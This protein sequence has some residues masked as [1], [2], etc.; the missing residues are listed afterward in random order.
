VLAD[1]KAAYLYIF[2]HHYYRIDS[3]YPTHITEKYVRSFFGEMKKFEGYNGFRTQQ[4]TGY[5]SI[6]SNKKNI[7]G[8]RLGFYTDSGT[9]VINLTRI[10]FADEKYMGNY[11]YKQDYP[12]S[13]LKE[14]TEEFEAEILPKILECIKI[15]KKK[16]E[17]NGESAN[18]ERDN[19]Y[20]KTYKYSKELAEYVEEGI[21]ELFDRY[22]ETHIT[23]EI[24][25]DCRN[26]YL[27]NYPNQPHKVDSL[28]PANIT[29]EYV[30]SFFG[31]MKKFEGV[32][33]YGTQ[34]QMG[35]YN[36]VSNKKNIY[37]ILLG[38]YLAEFGNKSTP[39]ISLIRIQFADEK[40]TGDY[41]YEQNYPK[42]K[43]KEARK[44]FETEIL[45][46][47]LECMEIAKNRH[48]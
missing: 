32:S 31:E 16:Y 18:Y 48:E 38:F 23:Q 45:P 12:K 37:R 3:L 1:Y 46:K 10:R 8:I 30:R 39:V 40:Y 22:P 24:L 34:R 29:E 25:T 44:E 4:Q 47:I 21:N 9:P 20:I 28:F 35:Y 42:S 2:P 11:P 17:E 15:A 26:A 41:I 27:Y 6:V 33:F 43:L 5:Y 19:T 7:Y 13:K 14:A 36:I